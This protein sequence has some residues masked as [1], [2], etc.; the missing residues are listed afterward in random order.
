MPEKDLLRDQRLIKTS[1]C[2]AKHRE[3][4]K[5]TLSFVESLS[6]VVPNEERRDP[7]VKHYIQRFRLKKVKEELLKMLYD[8]F[9]AKVFEK[10]LPSDMKLTWNGRLSSTAGYC[11]NQTRLGVRTCEIHISGKICTTPERL[12]DTLAHEMCHAA[13]FM[14]N[15]VNDGHGKIWRG[16]AN[17]FTLT[18]PD[19]PKITVTHTYF[20]EKKFIFKCT[21]CQLQ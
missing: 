15:L 17:L 2:M 13:S 19:M 10:Q 21:Q 18:Y 14:I 9:N 16:W 3:P 6:T 8:E 11:R 4:L 7:S 20:I 1:Q 5:K 12:R